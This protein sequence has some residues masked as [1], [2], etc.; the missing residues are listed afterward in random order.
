VVNI[1]AFLGFVNYRSPLDEF[2]ADYDQVHPMISASQRKEIEKYARIDALRDH[3]QEKQPSHET[4][5]WDV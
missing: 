4:E 2:L 5:E 1:K 3:P